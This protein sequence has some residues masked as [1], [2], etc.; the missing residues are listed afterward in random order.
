MKIGIS[1]T[2]SYDLAA[3]GSVRTGAR[4]MIERAVA[5]REAGLDSLFVGDHHVTGSPYYQNTPMLGRLLAEW[6]DADVGALYLLPLWQPVLLAEQIATLASIAEGR[7]IMQC[8]LGR[9]DDQFSAMGQSIRFRPSAFEESLKCLRQLWRGE[10]VSSQGR[11]HFGA[12]TISPIPPE[13][14]DVW[15]GANATVAIERAASMGDAWLAEPSLTVEQA[16]SAFN[17]YRQAREL[18]GLPMPDTIAIRRDIHVSE[19]PNEA[20]LV[21]RQVNQTGY[22]GFSMDALTFGDPDQVASEFRKLYEIGYTDII[23]RSLHPDQGHTI[24]SLQR[25]AKVKDLLK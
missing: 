5:A 25:L 17:T 21:Q 4:W 10:T 7:F 12:A 15:I 14:I 23:V 22:R 1:I 6:G 2:S 20:D 19:R 8:G 13:P 16:K 11:F 3:I 9:G 18:L 24:A